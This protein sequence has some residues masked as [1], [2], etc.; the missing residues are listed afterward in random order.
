MAKGLGFD[1]ESISQERYIELKNDAYELFD[2]YNSLERPA[3][4]DFLDALPKFNNYVEDLIVRTT[5]LFPDTE[6]LLM[7]TNSTEFNKLLNDIARTQDDVRAQDVAC[8]IFEYQMMGTRNLVQDGKLK[9]MDNLS[10]PDCSVSRRI[11]LELKNEALEGREEF[12]KL[13]LNK[14]AQFVELISED[15]NYNTQIQMATVMI[16]GDNEL[17]QQLKKCSV[18]EVATYYKVP[19]SLIQFKQEEYAMQG[20]KLLTSKFKIPKDSTPFSKLWYKDDLDA[21]RLSAISDQSFYK[22]VEDSC[23]TRIEMALSKIYA[24]PTK[25]VTK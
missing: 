24:E 25:K 4:W 5:L 9:V 14:K 15:I 20:T 13:S 23:L 17:I 12:L 19:E 7:A 16:P 8:K 10:Y 6:E 2:K 1:S 22:G 21:D 11:Y 3:R 18:A